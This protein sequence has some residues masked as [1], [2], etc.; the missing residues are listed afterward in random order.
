MPGALRPLAACYAALGRIEEAE[1]AIADLLTLSPDITVST[2]RRQVPWRNPEHTER[3]L[4]ALR[5]AG[6]PET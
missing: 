6:L 4:D 1:S 3:Y 5:K 2:T